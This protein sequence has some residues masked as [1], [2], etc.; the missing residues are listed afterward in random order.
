MAL[1]LQ[2]D[3]GPHFGVIYPLYW[4]RGFTAGLP[5]FL[6]CTVCSHPLTVFLLIKIK[7][8]Q[9]NFF[10]ITVCFH[11]VFLTYFCS[12][13]SISSHQ[14]CIRPLF[15]FLI[16][17]LI[18]HRARSMSKK[19]CGSLLIGIWPGAIDSPCNTSLSLV[20]LSKPR[21]DMITRTSDSRQ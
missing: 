16:K 13:S 10:S 12:I 19:S 18:C 8:L 6:H 1:A 7:H 4:R 17:H 20:G 11:T 5:A 3:S 21:S 9:K 14:L 15:F 2:V